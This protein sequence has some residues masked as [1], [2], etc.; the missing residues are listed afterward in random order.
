M[1][2]FL[3]EAFLLLRFVNVYKSAMHREHN[4]NENVYAQQYCFEDSL[5]N[6]LL[7]DE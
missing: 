1:G 2:N 7:E 5:A 6:D 3:S 4:R